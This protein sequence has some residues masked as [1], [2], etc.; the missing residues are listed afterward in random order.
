MENKNEIIG[1]RT[2]LPL[3]LKFGSEKIIATIDVVVYPKYR[4]KGSSKALSEKFYLDAKKRYVVF[5]AFPVK[6]ICEVR[7]ESNS[8]NNFCKGFTLWLILILHKKFLKYQSL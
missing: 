2:T 6:R 7:L 3:K 8:N 4:E 1:Y 5:F